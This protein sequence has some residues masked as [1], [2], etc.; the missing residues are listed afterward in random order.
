VRRGV[1]KHFG[2]KW[3]GKILGIRCFTDN[4]GRFSRGW[5]LESTNRI[6][7]MIINPL[8]VSQMANSIFCDNIC[9]LDEEVLNPKMSCDNLNS[10]ESGRCSSVV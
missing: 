2:G 8:P 10:I 9:K 7:R 6:I 1:R 3:A 4:A 5:R